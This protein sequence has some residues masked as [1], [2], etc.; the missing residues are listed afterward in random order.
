MNWNHE[1]SAMPQPTKLSCIGGRPRDSPIMTLT[2][3]SNE[4]A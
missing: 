3:S 1:N 4:N 2:Q